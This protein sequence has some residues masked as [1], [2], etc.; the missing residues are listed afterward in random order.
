MAELENI[1]NN[2]FNSVYAFAG[3]IL[4]NPLAK[5][6]ASTLRRPIDIKGLIFSDRI[7]SN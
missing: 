6:L 7:F 2:L 3:M 4:I 1:M 5:P